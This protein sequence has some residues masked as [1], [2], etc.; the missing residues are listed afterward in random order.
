MFLWKTFYWVMLLSLKYYWEETK[1]RTI[2]MCRHYNTGS[3]NQLLLYVYEDCLLLFYS[4]RT[5]MISSKNWVDLFL[6][7][8]SCVITI[9]QVINFLKVSWNILDK[10]VISCLI[11]TTLTMN[12]LEVL[13]PEHHVRICGEAIHIISGLF[14][15]FRAF[16]LLQTPL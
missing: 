9:C 15:A 8:S 10:K 6:P 14:S 2:C 13:N 3:P 5:W 16:W 7:N 4:H 1:S 12:L 11:F